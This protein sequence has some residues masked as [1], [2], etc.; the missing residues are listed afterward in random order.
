MIQLEDPYAD[1][2][3]DLERLT[4]WRDDIPLDMAQVVALEA[5]LKQIGLL[6]K[7]K[8]IFWHRF[9]VIFLSF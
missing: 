9:H 1:F 3:Q 8:S 6:W 2:E 7:R 4:A 5:E